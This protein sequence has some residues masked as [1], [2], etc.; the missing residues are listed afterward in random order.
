MWTIRR[1]RT[2]LGISIL[3]TAMVV[4][5]GGRGAAHGQSPGNA[6]AKAASRADSHSEAE[7]AARTTLNRLRTTQAED[8]VPVLEASSELVRALLANGRATA[9]ETIELTRRIYTVIERRA[10]DRR[11]QVFVLSLCAEALVAAGDYGEA[12]SVARRAVAL[13]RKHDTDAGSL[14]AAPLGQLGAALSG[15]GRHREAVQVL[16]QSL[17]PE[18]GQAGQ[19]P[20]SAA[21][22]SLEDLVRALQRLGDYRAAARSLR[23]VRTLQETAPADVASRIRILN[24]RAQQAWFEGRLLDARSHSEQAVALAEQSL[25]SGHPLL[26]SSLRYLAGTLGNLGHFQRSVELK[27]RA[28]RIAQEAFGLNHHLTAEYLHTLGVAEFDRGNYIYARQYLNRALDNYQRRYGSHHEDLAAAWSVLA[29]AEVSLGNLT[30]ARTNQER[31][32]EIHTRVGGPNHPYVAR[33]LVQLADIFRRQGAPSEAAGLLT[34]AL[35]IQEKHLGHEH[36][37]VART[38]ADLA[39]VLNQTGNTAGALPLAHRAGVIWDRL[40]VNDA[41]EHATVL[42]LTGAIAADRGD[43]EQARVSFERAVAIRARTL[44]MSH[45]LHADA[46]ISLAVTLAHLNQPAAALQLVVGA[47]DAARAHLALMLRS[48]SER[49]ALEY[50]RARPRGLDLLLSLASDQPSAVPHAADAVVRNRALVL[51]ELALRNAGDPRGTADPRS[52]RLRAAQQRLANL[53]VR[54]PGGLTPAVYTGVVQRAREEYERLEEVL[55]AQGATGRSRNA[56]GQ[57]GWTAILQK[58]PERAALVSLVRFNRLLLR[59]RATG[60]ERLAPAGGTPSYLALVNRPG[61]DPVVVP[62]GAAEELDALVGRW[63]AAVQQE[64]LSNSREDAGAHRSRAAGDSLRQR[65]W[66]PLV[67]HLAGARRVFIVPDGT[68]GLVPFAALPVGQRTYLV[69]AA[70]SFHYLTA[71][72]DLLTPG[73]DRRDMGRGL[74]AVGGADFGADATTQ[75]P[76]IQSPSAPGPQP[77]PPV[78]WLSQARGTSCRDLSSTRFPP[79]F[80]SRLEVSEITGIWKQSAAPDS[81]VITWLAGREATEELVKRDA[82]KFRVVHLATH[83]FF[84]EGACK[85]G[86]SNDAGMMV[87]ANPLLMAGLAFSGANHRQ[88][89]PIDRDDG[90]LMAEEVSAL[91]LRG[92]EWVVLSACDSGVGQPRADEGVFGLRRAFQ[93]AGVQ[94]VIMSLWAVDDGSARDWMRR[95]YRNRFHVGLPTAD[96]VQAATVDTLRARRDLNLSTNPL[97]WAGFVAAGDWR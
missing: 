72:R 56:T 17:R 23:R 92:V 70:P 76:G 87:D 21:R 35:A 28:L 54:G 37:D 34:R 77:R 79:L 66:D 91:Y 11:M 50:A 85:T 22:R 25:R 9:A 16:E 4:S 80:G 44:G 95:L 32:L 52:S 36:R 24:L 61:S 7:A 41:P 46:Q 69:E 93:M 82:H 86:A 1:T 8:S 55:A 18:E 84:L 75:G 81:G 48:L 65:I 94:T 5:A 19:P 88:A 78:L 39:A 2:A 26:A 12:I 97:Y 31:A 3:A 62:L 68:L 67:P 57:P 43:Y 53:L 49:Q 10:D 40:G 73:V 15:A 63:R 83:G 38:V 59:A 14:A 6:P 90:I 58:L 71:E 74:L 29:E 42:A 64:A 96:A 89:V 60:P 27:Q 33:A 30:G 45:P 13:A 51:D 20:T 47:E